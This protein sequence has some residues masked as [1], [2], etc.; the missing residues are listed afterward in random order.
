ML[1][2]DRLAVWACN[3]IMGT[4]ASSWQRGLFNLS[5]MYPVPSEELNDAIECVLISVLE[6]MEQ[7]QIDDDCELIADINELA[8][9]F[10]AMTGLSE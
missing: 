10:S 9:V 4:V 5:V 6:A 7:E 1:D 3:R 8:R 2:R